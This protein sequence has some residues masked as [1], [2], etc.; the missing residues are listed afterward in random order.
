MSGAGWFRA[1]GANA[2]RCGAEAAGSPRVRGG[3]ASQ[4][5]GGARQ[6]PAGVLRPHR[7][8]A[9]AGGTAQLPDPPCS[10][11][12]IRPPIGTEDSMRTGMRRASSVK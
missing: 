5:S 11:S 12:T 4:A 8:A 9:L 7:R 10:E 1:R 3:G 2:A 6:R